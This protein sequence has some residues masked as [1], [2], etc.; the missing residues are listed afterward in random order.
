MRPRFTVSKGIVRVLAVLSAGIVFGTGATLFAQRVLI[1]DGTQPQKPAVPN[2][3]KGDTPQHQPGEKDR[4]AD[5]HGIKMS[6]EK[7]ATAKIGLAKVGP[8]P[9]V[10]HVVVPGTIVPDQDRAC[11]EVK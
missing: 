11:A 4:R 7:I 8:G 3:K 10:R 5:D 9:L 1:A 6:A 2:V